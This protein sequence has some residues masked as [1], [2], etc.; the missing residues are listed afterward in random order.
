M[1]SEIFGA[2][3][4]CAPDAGRCMMDVDGTAIDDDREGRTPAVYN[5]PQNCSSLRS[6]EYAGRV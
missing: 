3:K 4:S 1:S 5:G 2:R 6:S